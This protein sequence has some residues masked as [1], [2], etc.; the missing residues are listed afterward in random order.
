MTDKVNLN[1]VSTFVND[2]TAVSVFNNNVSAITS[3]FDNTLSLTPVAGTNNSM[4]GNLDMNSNQILN[5]P[6][7]ASMNSPARLVDV[8]SNPTISVPPVG[9]S[10]AV[11]G[12]LNASKTDSG[13]NTFSGINIINV[14]G[15]AL[16]TSPTG[17]PTGG[18]LLTTFS[19]LDCQVNTVS[20][21]NREFVLN[22]GL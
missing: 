20:N 19:S 21:T 6:S 11:V 5:L 4:N 14:G 7:P 3:G 13:N 22:V 10:G 2:T 1:T 15:Q 18:S 17:N 16:S 12:L 9:T 8:A